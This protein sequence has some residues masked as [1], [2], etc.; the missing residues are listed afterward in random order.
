MYWQ[1]ASDFDT[2]PVLTHAKR[3]GNMLGGIAGLALLALVFYFAGMAPDANGK[4][5]VFGKK[6]FK[7][8]MPLAI[9][10][11]IALVFL[12]LIFS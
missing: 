1:D 10:I 2:L 12:A 6:A 11:V 8:G 7:S 9:S 3:G 5:D 4:E